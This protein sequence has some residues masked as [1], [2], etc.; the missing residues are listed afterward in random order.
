MLYSLLSQDT[1][2]DPCGGQRLLERCVSLTAGSGGGPAVDSGSTDES[3]VIRMIYTPRGYTPRQ[4]AFIRKTPPV[5]ASPRVN[6]SNTEVEMKARHSRTAAPIDTKRETG[7]TFSRR[8]LFLHF[9]GPSKTPDVQSQHRVS[10]L[11]SFCSL[12]RF[13]IAARRAGIQFLPSLAHIPN[14]TSATLS[15]NLPAF[16]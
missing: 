3:L 12:P 9:I 2:Q 5:D 16:R 1:T 11:V 6:G 4:K 15:Q 14:G 8:C 13:N 10:S 7:G